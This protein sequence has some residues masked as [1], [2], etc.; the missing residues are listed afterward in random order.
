[1]KADTRW[2]RQCADDIDATGGSVRKLLGPADG[3]VSTLKAAAPGWDFTGSV[4]EM[5]SRWETLNKVVRDELSEAAENIRF[6]ASS[7][8]GNENVITEMWHDLFG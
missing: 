7:H 4:D 2:M 1:M 6:N 8:D 5:S 3:A